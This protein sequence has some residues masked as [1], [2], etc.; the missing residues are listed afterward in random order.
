MC[1]AEISFDKNGGLEVLKSQNK[2][3]VGFFLL[4]LF[5]LLFS[6]GFFYDR[7]QVKT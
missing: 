3:L 1:F 5:V 7:Q 2:S 6:V 4:F